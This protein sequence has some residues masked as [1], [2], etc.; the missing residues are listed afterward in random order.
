[1]NNQNEISAISN[2]LS[3]LQ[4]KYDCETI[5]SLIPSLQRDGIT[6]FGVIPYI[7]LTTASA[8]EFLDSYKNDVL[9][10]SDILQIQ[11]VRLKLKV[12]EDGYSKSKKMILNIDFLQDQVFKN[13]LRF[14]FMRNWNIHL[15]LGIYTDADKRVVGNTQYNYYLLQDNRFLKKHTE[16]VAKAYSISPNKFNLTEQSEKASYEYA[17]KCGQVIGSVRSGFSNFDTPVSITVKNNPIN[18]YY[19]DYNTNIKSSLFPSGDDGKATTLYLLHTL[20]TINFLL[21][22]LNGYEK[23]DNGWWL[24]LNYISY[25]Y[26]IHKLRDLQQHLIQNK[27]CTPDISDYFVAIGLDNSKYLNS[28][29]RNYVMHSQLTDKDGSMLIT[30]EN[31]DKAKPLFG[32][33][34]TCFD[35]KT[36]NELKQLIIFETTKISNILS[37]WLGIQNLHIKPLDK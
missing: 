8:L 22:I 13:M 37:E 1:M 7:S 26:A 2:Y 33:V 14:N 6:A 24:K 31:L 10:K 23:D 12:F 25:Y 11:D 21:Y 29:F 32:L 30:K 16:E 9:P 5:C 19:A 27:L 35:G 17:Y 3:L 15:N 34:E 20:S 4:L 28:S 36:Y 18:Y